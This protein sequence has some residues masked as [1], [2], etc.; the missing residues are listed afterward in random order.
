MTLKEMSVKLKI[1]KTSTFHVKKEREKN[2][3]EIM[4]YSSDFFCLMAF[5]LPNDT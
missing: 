2:I 5:K 4:K 1:R 3:L